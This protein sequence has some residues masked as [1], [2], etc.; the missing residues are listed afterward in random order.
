MNH[1]RNALVTLS[2]TWLLALGALA[3]HS[4]EPRELYGRLIAPCCWN[5]TLDIH[6]SE[7]ATQLR[8]EIAE[9]L[10]RREP[11]LSIE[12]D[13]AR[14]FGERIRAVPRAQ[15]PRQSMA[16]AVTGTMVFVLAGLLLL[17]L[18]WTR[19]RAIQGEESLLAEELRS[20]YEARLDRELARVDS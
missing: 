10:A 15:D 13:L 5:Q 14:R 20:E 12:D 1:L 19:K 7:L 8:V 17:A 4:I 2:V 6:D 11:E 18:R 16:L 9:R 3:E